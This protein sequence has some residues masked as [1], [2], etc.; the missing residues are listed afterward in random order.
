[1]DPN[2]RFLGSQLQELKILGASDR[3]WTVDYKDGKFEN[4]L[5][6]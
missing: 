4:V 3:L 5:L 2:N 6:K 1:M